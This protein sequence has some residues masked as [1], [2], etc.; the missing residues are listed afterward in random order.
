VIRTYVAVDACGNTSEFQQFITLIDDNDPFFTVFPEDVTVDCQ[1]VPSADVAVEG[2]DICTET[3]ITYD[4][5]EIIEGDCEGNYTIVR[6]WTI[7]DNCDNSV[8][9]S[10]TITVEDTTPPVFTSVPEGG[11]YSCEDE[12]DYGMPMAEDNCSSFGLDMSVDTIPG[13]CPQ[14]FTIVRTWVAIDA[15][16]NASETVGAEY[17]VFDNVAPVITTQPA[18]VMVECAED[19]PAIA[20]V[21]AVDNCGDVTINSDEAYIEAPDECGNYVKEITYVAVDECGNTSEPVSYTIT[22][23][24]MTAPELTDLPAAELVLDCDAEVPAAPEVGAIDNCDGEVDIIFTENIIGET[25]MMLPEGASEICALSTPEGPFCDNND[26]WS[27]HLFSF[28][29]DVEFFTTIQGSWVEYPD[30]T[31]HIQATVQSVEYPDGGLVIDVWFENGVDWDEWNEQEFPTNYKDDCDLAGDE[32]LNWMYYLMSADQATL[33]GT[34]SLEGT[35]LSLTHAPAN[36]YYGYQLGVAANNMNDAFGSGGWFT[37]DGVLV[38][39]GEEYQIDGLSGDFAFEHDCCPQYQIERC[40]TAVDCSGNESEQFCQIISFAEGGEGG[41]D[42][43]VADERPEAIM[44]GSFDR[45]DV[46]ITKLF[47]NPT[48]D[49]ATI[50]YGSKNTANVELKIYNMNG[51][52]V[53]TL[54]KGSID[55]GVLYR[56][57]IEVGN[58]N[59]GVYTIMLISGDDVTY[60]RLIV[61]K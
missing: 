3:E 29:A 42:G 14:S 19:A 27:V 36:F 49:V 54:F 46:A 10:W 41:N 52:E 45:G 18:D 37:T 30:G 8:S 50:E 39:N 59:S 17:F 48:Y 55:G 15:C 13:E 20:E 2:D 4:G 28:P 16:G 22:V 35:F 6:T 61:T 58:M 33:V 56:K 53:T 5:E 11:E 23:F 51:A 12:I 44:P 24:D 7:T 9:Q 57:D 26:P 25:G 38:V 60:E 43:V 21:S 31:A 40:W 32:Y 47:P 1:Q 34:G